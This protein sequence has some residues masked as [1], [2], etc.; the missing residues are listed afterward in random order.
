VVK[1]YLITI[2]K[3]T[4]FLIENMNHS[5]SYYM[6]ALSPEIANAQALEKAKHLYPSP[7]RA[8][9]AEKNVFVR[10]E[11]LPPTSLMGRIFGF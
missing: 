3:R 7:T 1:R 9:E 2:S 5:V 10:V 6:R 4:T 11:E 8:G